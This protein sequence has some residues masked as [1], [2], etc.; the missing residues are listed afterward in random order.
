MDLDYPTE[1]EQA[2]MLKFTEDPL[3]S[4]HQLLYSWSKPLTPPPEAGA[5]AEPAALRL[6]PIVPVGTGELGEPGSL[7]PLGGDAIDALPLTTTSRPIS[8]VG[9]LQ[10]LS[11]LLASDAPLD[12]DEWV[13]APMEEEVGAPMA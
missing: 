5:P 2:D 8:K 9:S 10:A 11:E 7:Y 3:V 1:G 4:D 6:L 13:A 12:V